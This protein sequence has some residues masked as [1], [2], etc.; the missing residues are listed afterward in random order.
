MNMLKIVARRKTG[1]IVKGYWQAPPELAPGEHPTVLPDRIA[2]QVYGTT[3][4]AVV[5]T[6]SL[7][8]V[9][10]VKR[11]SGNPEY[12][13]IKFFTE[14]PASDDVWVKLRFI[15]KE[16]LEGTIHNGLDAFIQPGFLFRPADAAS[17]NEAL[18]VIKSSLVELKILRVVDIV[19]SRKMRDFTAAVGR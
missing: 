7:K 9:Y 2:L 17:N 1:D 3:E 10:F 4:T 5:E 11:L 19:S 18:Y 6:D 15:D 14:A 8:A 12:R 13:E 16:T